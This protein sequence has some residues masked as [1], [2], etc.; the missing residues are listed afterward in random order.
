MA[1][2]IPSRE[3]LHRLAQLHRFTLSDEE[4]ETYHA[5][6]PGIFARL[7]QLDQMPEPSVPR[8]YPT[9]DPGQRP[10]SRHDPYN[11]IVRRCS[12]MGAAEGLLAG[13]RIGLKDNICVAG[14][15]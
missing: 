11:A 7:D 10:A 8:Q 3:E 13:K 4:V 2:R 14:R 5:R 9:R 1:L 6:L 15:E 12:A